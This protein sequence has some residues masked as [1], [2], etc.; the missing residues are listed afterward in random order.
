M[1]GPFFVTSV[2]ALLLFGVSVGAEAARFA[3]RQEN[4]A[5]WL[6][7]FYPGF[8]VAAHAFPNSEPTNALYDRSETMSSPLR[9]VGYPIVAV[10]KAVN[11]L[12]FLWVDALYAIGLY[13]LVAIPVGAI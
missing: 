9:L 11:A 5:L 3:S 10:S 13:L 8:A 7:L 2:L 12:R 6:V 4:V 1:L